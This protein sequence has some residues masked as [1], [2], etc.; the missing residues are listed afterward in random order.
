MARPSTI[1][2]LLDTA[3]LR[4]DVRWRRGRAVVQDV[5][6]RE[7]ERR[8]AAD[9][10]DE[11]ATGAPLRGPVLVLSDEVFLQTIE[12]S[13]KVIAGL[14]GR[15]LTSAIAYEARTFSGLDGEAI[16]EWWRRGD[17]REF[18]V[19]QL[20]EN[21][22]AA[23]TEAVDRAGGTLLGIA[24]PAAVPVSLREDASFVRR[25]E[26]GSVRA[27]VRGTNGPAERVHVSRRRGAADDQTNVTEHLVANAATAA[28]P[29]AARFE[30][31][32][33]A[34]VTAWLSAWAE[35]AGRDAPHVMLSPPETSGARNRRFLFASIALAAVIGI[36]LLYRS[37]V[38]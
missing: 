3:V 18:L 34:A 20:A 4:A 10:I 11:L 16:T 37:C 23:I 13:P 6:R 5:I 19:A 25:E 15:A 32:D 30:L 28:L 2:V 29:D 1:L 33:D 31:G 26:W 27:L 8:E 17:E 21:D 12:L 24:H 14:D 22:V 35:S 36:G 38:K 7:R 9:A